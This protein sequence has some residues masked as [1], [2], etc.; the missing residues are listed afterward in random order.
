MKETYT[1]SSPFRHRVTIPLLPLTFFMPLSV[2]VAV[3]HAHCGS[4][5]GR[6]RHATSGSPE[7][8]PVPIKS[9]SVVIG[10]SNL[11]VIE[12]GRGFP[13]GRKEGRGKTN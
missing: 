11:A 3:Q 1:S 13:E 10:L 12:V 5:G 9:T 8:V 2:L 7:L 4:F 6:V